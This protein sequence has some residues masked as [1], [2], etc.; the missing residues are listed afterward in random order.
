MKV[1]LRYELQPDGCRRVVK[2]PWQRA[3]KHVEL[4]NIGSG[5]VVAAG[6]R[7]AWAATRNGRLA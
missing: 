6:E 1:K 4:F 3:E 7:C 5:Q 2:P